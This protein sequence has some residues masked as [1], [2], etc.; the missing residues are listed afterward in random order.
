[1]GCTLV[2]SKISEEEA[3]V[4]AEQAL[5][6]HIQSSTNLDLVFRKYS[7]NYKLNHLQ[8]TRA[9]ENLGLQICNIS[10][11]TN[12]SLTFNRLKDPDDHYNLQDLIMISVLLGKDSLY[13]KAQILYQSLD[14]ELLGY[15]TVAQVTGLVWNILKVSIDVM[16]GLVCDGQTPYTSEF[17]VNKYLY[18]L[19]IVKKDVAKSLI[20]FI[21]IGHEKVKETC[22]IERL[23]FYKEGKFLN[24][25]WVRQEI[26]N[27]YLAKIPKKTLINTAINNRP[28]R[29]EI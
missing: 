8:F 18:Q 1:M 12:I 22:F 5:N 17:R 16:G 13:D 15:L 21:M 4:K 23:V 25:A 11:Y 6:F 29:N 24:S 10:Q 19:N 2:P 7:N 9:A 26:Y 14:K 28:L 27:Y 3:I 20:E